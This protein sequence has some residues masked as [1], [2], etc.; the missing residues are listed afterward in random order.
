MCTYTLT[1]TDGTTEAGLAAGTETE[2]FAYL[3]EGQ[4]GIKAL[5]VTQVDDLTW[6]G[7]DECPM[8]E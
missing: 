7:A 8:G 5:A 3:S 2:V 6:P 4:V 1:L